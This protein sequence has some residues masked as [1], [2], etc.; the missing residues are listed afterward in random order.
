MYE[1][2]H[3]IRSKNIRIIKLEAARSE[4]DVSESCDFENTFSRNISGS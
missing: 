3:R 4:T 2:I 1:N